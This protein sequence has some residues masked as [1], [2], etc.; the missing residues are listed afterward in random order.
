MSPT[1]FLG[2]CGLAAALFGLLGCAP[3]DQPRDY[4]RRA[5]RDL[6]DGYPCRSA[7][8][9]AV[10]AQGTDTV[11]TVTPLADATVELR[12]RQASDS[13]LRCDV[14]RWTGTQPSEPQRLYEVPNAATSLNAVHARVCHP[15]SDR[16]AA[17]QHVRRAHI[18]TG[19]H[20]SYTPCGQADLVRVAEVASIWWLDVKKDDPLRRT[21]YINAETLQRLLSERNTFSRAAAIDLMLTLFDRAALYPNLD[22]DQ[23]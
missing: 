22:M 17:P 20:W 11:I 18:T 16:H 23:R 3:V 12:I 21:R 2:I 15:T 13:D 6:L 10:L 9:A 1:C 19:T 7:V 4:V 8:C 14:L 5:L